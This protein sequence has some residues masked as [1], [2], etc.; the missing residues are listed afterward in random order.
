MLVMVY[1]RLGIL[2]EKKGMEQVVSNKGY[3]VAATKVYI[4]KNWISQVKTKP[5]DGYD[6]CQISTTLTSENKVNRPLLFHFK[7]ANIPPQK[8][9]K[10]IRYMTNFKAGDSIGIEI[11][12]EGE[13]VKV[14]S[15]SKGRGFSGMIKR[16]NKRRGPKSHGSGHHRGV[17]STGTGRDRNRVIKGKKMPGRMGGKKVTIS[18]RVTIEKIDRENRFIFL[19]GGLPGPRGGLITVTKEVEVKE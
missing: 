15:I 18:S 2:G 19:K 9:I 17:G 14:S 11:F 5:K 16:H 10:E 3:L 1:N 8:N 7:K 6:A 13:K 4:E 12:S